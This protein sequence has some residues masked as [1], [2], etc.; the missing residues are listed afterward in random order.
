[1]KFCPGWGNRAYRVVASGA[2]SRRANGNGHGVGAEIERRE[3]AGPAL[4][5]SCFLQEVDQ[6]EE[7]EEIA[8]GHAQQADLSIHRRTE[9]LRS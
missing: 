9:M 2:C 8:R 6:K 3:A 4:G 1:M 5:K 7:A